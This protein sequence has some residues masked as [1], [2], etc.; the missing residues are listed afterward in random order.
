MFLMTLALF[1][2]T[3]ST[4]DSASS[5]TDDDNDGYPAEEDCDDNDAAVNPGADEICDGLDNDCDEQID[6]DA[7]DGGTWYADVD[8]DGFG[9]ESNPVFDCTQPADLIAE[10]GDCD[11]A[12]ATVFPG[13][14]ELCNE[15]DDDCDGETDEDAVDPS[16]F[17]TDADSDGYGDAESPVEAC[18]A[19]SGTVEDDSDCDDGNVLANPGEAE[20]C[21]DGFDN[22]CDG[23]D[24]GCATTGAVPVSDA[25]V[26]LNG[27]SAGDGAGQPLRGVGDLSGDGLDDLAVSARDADLSAE[28]A[29][30]VYL[31]EGGLS[32]GQYELA[33][34]AWA[35][36]TGGAAGDNL[37][38]VWGVGDMDGDGDGDLAVSSQLTDEVGNNAGTVYLFYGAL[39]GEVSVSSADATV[40]AEAAGDQFGVITFSGDLDDDGTPDLLA[41]APNN[42][43]NGSN[44]GSAYLF[45]GPVSDMEADQGTLVIRGEDEGDKLGGGLSRA[46]DVDGDGVGDFLIG[47]PYDDDGGEDAG[48]VLVFYGGSDLSGTVSASDADLKVTGSAGDELGW[49]LSEAGDHDG[50]GLGDWLASARRRDAGGLNAAGGIYLVPGSLASDS[51]AGTAKLALIK[52]AGA[53]DKISNNHGGQDVNADGSPDVLVGAKDVS[54]AGEASGAAYL[55]YGP[56]SGTWGADEADAV[57]SGE[58]AGD[59]V[60][61][62][63]N[64]TGDLNGDGIG[65]F[66][67][68]GRG[69]DEGTGAAYIFFGSGL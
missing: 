47:V 32:A 46:G 48:A 5:W 45:A 22:D 42:D 14:D 33:D 16:T 1:A 17:Y 29:G 31:V 3:K 39:S 65:D 35:V 4:G 38:G 13:A 52:G 20:I 50:D 54:G 21:D 68:G 41:T 30:A 59:E 28:D 64:L 51:D 37:K 69:V 56:L 43:D 61:A 58:A 6:V 25:D 27:A 15:I 55:F 53:E 57:F 67:V 62:P 10:G 7:V 23:T 18:S 60:G 2:C 66:G 19:P 9:D 34:Q 49:G 44:A 36:I 63:V 40:S 11:D 26:V 12:S 8:Q 24:N